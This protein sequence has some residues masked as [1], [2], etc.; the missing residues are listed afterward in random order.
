MHTDKQDFSDNTSF[1]WSLSIDC[2][3]WGAE[4]TE[5]DKAR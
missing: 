4:Q 1:S 5:E 2:D 3:W